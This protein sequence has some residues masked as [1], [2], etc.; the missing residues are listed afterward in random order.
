MN[1]ILFE[2]DAVKAE[3]NLKKHKVSF[4][5]GLTVFHD[6]SVATISDPA[7]SET[8][9]RSIAIGISNKGRLLVV[10][11]VDR[12]DRIRLISCRKATKKERTTYEKI[13][14]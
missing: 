8:E 2:W 14:E 7:H 10:S 3:S 4:H 13:N 6:L 9:I 5:E 11:F 1:E 12:V